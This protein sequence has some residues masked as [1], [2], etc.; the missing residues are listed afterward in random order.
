M[1]FYYHVFDESSFAC[2][3]PF[4]NSFLP[5]TY[6]PPFSYLPYHHIYRL[7]LDLTNAKVRN[8]WLA[9]QSQLGLVELLAKRSSVTLALT[10]S[11]SSTLSNRQRPHLRTVPPSRQ[12]A[13]IPYWSPFCRTKPINEI[14]TH[15]F[16][17][18]HLYKLIFWKLYKFPI[19][20]LNDFNINSYIFLICLYVLYK[21]FLLYIPE[22]RQISSRTTQ[23]M[24]NRWQ[25]P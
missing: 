9:N 1:E 13:Y 25:L 15:T 19:I 4:F 5:A 24:L 7:S 3:S 2:S 10:K 12:V 21:F 16:I 22:E 8:F 23:S 6:L 11:R 18:S 14:I 17:F 20:N